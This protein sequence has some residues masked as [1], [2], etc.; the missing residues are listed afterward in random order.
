[1]ADYPEKTCTIDTL[2]TQPR[3]VKLALSG[4]KTQ[5]RR[6]GVYAY[7]GETFE[8]QGVTFEVT[9]LEKQRLGDMSDADAKA[10]GFPDLEAYKNIILKMHKGMGWNDNAQVWLHVFGR[11]D[12]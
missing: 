2:V 10:E 9:A 12:P 1:M 7:P 4:D 6:N 11:R 5:Q 8:L 3:L